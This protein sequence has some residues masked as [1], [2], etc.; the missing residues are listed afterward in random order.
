VPEIAGPPVVAGE[1]IALRRY[2]VAAVIVAVN[3]AM[4][5]VVARARIPVA[6][7]LGMPILAGAP[8]VA[9]EFAH[10]G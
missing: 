8:M 3:I 7:P 5:V 9:R 4:I 6:T 2:E 1:V 10:L